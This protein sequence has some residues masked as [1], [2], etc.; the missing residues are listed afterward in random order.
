MT[1][2][3]LNLY[4]MCWICKCACAVSAKYISITQG[5]RARYL[6]SLTAIRQSVD[7][8]PG[9]FFAVLFLWS[10]SLL[11]ISPLSLWCGMAFLLAA[12]F[13]IFTESLNNLFLYVWFTT[14]MLLN[15]FFVICWKKNVFFSFFG[16]RRIRLFA[17]HMKQS[18]IRHTFWHFVH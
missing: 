15:V 9:F 2:I 13:L 12:L 6:I 18:P 8:L 7:L 17:R 14:R 3:H 10:Q 16:G 4:V 11:F 1:S 5:Y